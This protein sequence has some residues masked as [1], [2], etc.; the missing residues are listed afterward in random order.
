MRPYLCLLFMMLATT[1]LAQRKVRLLMTKADALVQE[2]KM[3]DAI[4]CYQQIVQRHHKSAH[5][6]AAMLLMGECYREMDSIETAKKW[7][8]KVLQTEFQDQGENYESP[9]LHTNI[10][11][12]SAVHLGNM[13]YNQGQYQQGANY[14]RL[15]TETHPFVHI[16][17]R[18][19]QRQRVQLAHWLADCYQ[20]MNKQDSLIWTLLPEALMAG[21]PHGAASASQRLAEYGVAQYGYSTFRQNLEEGLRT[22]T[23]DGHIMHLR[24][25]GLLV[26]V[27]VSSRKE[28]EVLIG[29]M[30]S[31]DF[32]QRLSRTVHRS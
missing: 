24:F 29:Q 28:F 4:S 10:R 27:Q 22:A 2:G 16:S 32:Y 9:D 15:A 25:N 12:K 6:P 26:R 3:Q 8:L 5:Y 20:K 1:G 19:T 31:S 17:M 13:F 30:P 21:T 18:I 11:H 7:F 23:L 14:Y